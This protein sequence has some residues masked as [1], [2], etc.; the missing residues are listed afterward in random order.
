[1]QILW[2]SSHWTQ[3]F[4]DLPVNGQIYCLFVCKFICFDVDSQT[5]VKTSYLDTKHF[6]IKA[7]NWTEAQLCFDVFWMSKHSDMNCDLE[8]VLLLAYIGIIYYWEVES[9]V[10]DYSVPHSRTE[11][12]N[13][14]LQYITG[15]QTLVHFRQ[16]QGQVS[17]IREFSLF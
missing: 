13:S 6:Q 15:K 7:F 5:A 1:M 10:S 14:L 16:K 11:R 12:K 3:Y 17:L 9:F 4:L 2:L 8:M